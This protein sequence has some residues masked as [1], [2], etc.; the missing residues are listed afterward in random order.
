MAKPEPAW[1]FESQDSLIFF[2]MSLI[3]CVTQKGF[4]LDDIPYYNEDQ[5][6][7]GIGGALMTLPDFLDMIT[8]VD[9]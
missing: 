1:V 3:G 6:C 7:F 8:Q 9:G 4:S 2:G 5:T